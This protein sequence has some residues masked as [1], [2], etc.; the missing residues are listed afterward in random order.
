MEAELVVGYNPLPAAER[1]AHYRQAVRSRLVWLLVGLVVV[2]VIYVW[3][4]DVLDAVATALLFVVGLGFAVAWLALSTVQWWLARR[5]LSR[6][7]TVQGVALRISVEGIEIA[8]RQLP[9]ESI[10]RVHTAKGP[11]GAGVQLAV[12][13]SEGQTSTVPLTYLDSM[14]GTLDSAVRAYSGGRRWLDTSGLGN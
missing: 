5:Q 6:V 14:P 4:R 8:D 11:P 2:M 13:D 9:W 10:A 7:N 3:Q 12:T 1:V